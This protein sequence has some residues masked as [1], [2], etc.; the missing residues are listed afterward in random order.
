MAMDED[1][2]LPLSGLAQLMYCERL[3]ALIHIEGLW[4]EN[5][6]TVEGSHLHKK[7]DT[8][9]IETRAGV[10]SA[11]ATPLRSLRLGLSGKA[12]VIE[13]HSTQGGEIAYPVEY[14]RSRLQKWQ[15]PCW[16]VQLCAQGMCLEEMLGV[17]VPAGAIYFG[18]SHRRQEVPFTPELRRTTEEASSR[19]HALVAARLTPPAVHDQRCEH[20]S[21]REHCMPAVTREGRSVAAWLRK[22]LASGST[23]ESPP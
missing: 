17:G 8:V 22:A 11:R 23:P 21:L 14:K 9:A 10:R 20:C 4:N 18:G 3:A 13:F 6:Y 16:E 5:A 15:R 19:F 7:A 2:L 12:D 1:S